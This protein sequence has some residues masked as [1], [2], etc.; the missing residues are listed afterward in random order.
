MNP[1]WMNPDDALLIVDVQRDFCPGGNLAVEGGDRVVPILNRW[2][3]AA[4]ECGARIV[5]SRDWHPPGHVSFQSQ[6]GN[7]PEHCV[8]ETPGAEFHPDLHLPQE[9]EI[10]SKGIRSDRDAYSP[11]DG[12]GLADRL[13]RAGVHR[14][15]LGGLT[16]D[17]CVRQTALDARKSG[18]EVH[19]ITDAT[20]PVDPAGG[21]A[22][23]QEM[24]AAG[25]FVDNTEE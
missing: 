25:V 7:W 12:T 24:R 17:V 6:G 4:Q 15:F 5:A 8:K 21:E 23:I 18:F 10:V 9:V 16:L 2:I 11:F 14:I 3:A 20:F 1:S 22:A 13:R 19:L